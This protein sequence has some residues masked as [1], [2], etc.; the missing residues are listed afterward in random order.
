MIN[1]FR[2]SLREVA[3]R[4]IRIVFKHNRKLH[5][6][7]LEYGSEFLFENGCVIV[8]YRFRNAICYRFG[9][10]WTTEDKVVILNLSNIE[11]ELVFTVFGL[12]QS[13]QYRI[14]AVPKARLDNSQFEKG[15]CVKPALNKA[16]SLKINSSKIA[17]EPVRVAFFRTTLQW[18][19]RP[20]FSMNDFNQNELI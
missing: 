8:H 14:S 2:F 20:S 17:V 13:R 4:L 5:C 7:Q 16:G 15:I 10:Y 18:P 6:E 3:G 19:Y 11:S 1:H 12:F 9:K